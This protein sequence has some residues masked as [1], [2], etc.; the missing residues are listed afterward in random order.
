VRRIHGR[1]PVR[2][3]RLDGLE[4]PGL[5]LLAFFFGPH[6]GLPVGSQDQTGAKAS[7]PKQKNVDKIPRRAS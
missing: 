7:N 2:V 6:N 4:S 5:A 3:E 1:R